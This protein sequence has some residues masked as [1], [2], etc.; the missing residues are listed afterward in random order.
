MDHVA[1]IAQGGTALNQA[2]YRRSTTR[3]LARSAFQ[4]AISFL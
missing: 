4:Y 3:S 1:A 2:G